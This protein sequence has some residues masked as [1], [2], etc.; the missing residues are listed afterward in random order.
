VAN[1]GSLSRS[2]WIAIREQRPVCRSMHR[3]RV[4]VGTDATAS[5]QDRLDLA[6][7]LAMA[8]L[9][10]SETLIANSVYGH[11][12]NYRI[13]VTSV[14]ILQLPHIGIKRR[15]Q[16]GSHMT[17]K[18]QG[19]ATVC[20]MS[21]HEPSQRRTAQFTPTLKTRSNNSLPL[22]TQTSDQ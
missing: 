17:S 2:F 4:E 15:S 14:D 10:A 9:T 8:R 22:M 16:I 5:G 1:R 6:R 20:L 12:V 13:D 11:T 19:R 18:W 7:V 3:R 21:V